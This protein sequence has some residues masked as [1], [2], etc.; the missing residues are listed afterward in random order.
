MLLAKCRKVLSPYLET[1]GP[2]QMSRIVRIALFWLCAGMAC[3]AAAK[4]PDTRTDLY[5]CKIE[6]LGRVVVLHYRP[7][8]TPAPESGSTTR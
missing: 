7:D 3:H 1:G 2:A 8:G 5:E 4:K 6:H